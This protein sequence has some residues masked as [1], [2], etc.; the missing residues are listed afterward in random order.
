MPN[1]EVKLFSADGSWGISPC[2][3]RTLPGKEES[4]RPN[5]LWLFCIQKMLKP[6]KRKSFMKDNKGLLRKLRRGGRSKK[7]EEASDDRPEWIF[8]DP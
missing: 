2:K 1:T 6:R 8:G 7:F 3:S 4:Q 5:G